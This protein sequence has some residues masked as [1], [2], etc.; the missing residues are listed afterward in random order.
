MGNSCCRRSNALR[1]LPSSLS[2]SVMYRAHATSVQDGA[3]CEERKKSMRTCLHSLALVHCFLI[4]SNSE[5]GMLTYSPN[6]LHRLSLMRSRTVERFSGVRLGS[7]RERD[8]GGR[9][10][11]NIIQLQVMPESTHK[12]E[13]VELCTNVTE[14]KLPANVTH[15][16]N[17]TV[18]MKSTE[19][20]TPRHILHN[21][22]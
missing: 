4:L 15:D 7:E 12:G 18:T 8:S 22:I 13:N 9:E 2:H 3:G 21:Y 19:V 5:Y 17:I 10:G 14:K 1:Q 20:Q 11:V 6:F 16:V